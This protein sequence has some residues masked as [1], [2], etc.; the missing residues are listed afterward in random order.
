[1]GSWQHPACP[2]GILGILETFHSPT[3]VTLALLPLWPRFPQI[4]TA[5]TES[6]L[7]S[8]RNTLT[9]TQKGPQ[10]DQG[11]PKKGL[12]DV[13]CTRQQKGA[14]C[15]AFSQLLPELACHGTSALLFPFPPWGKPNHLQTHEVIFKAF[16]ADFSS[17]FPCR[18]TADQLP[19]AVSPGSQVGGRVQGRSKALLDKGE[20]R[21]G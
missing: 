18:E 4:P 1:M 7:P 2:R 6:V 3:G 5:G 13:S 14:T 21:R 19:E 8:S 15:G 9:R 10:K 16:K 20:E 12:F 11:V 17:P